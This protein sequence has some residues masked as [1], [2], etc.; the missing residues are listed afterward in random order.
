[1]EL[2]PQST[3]NY[4]TVYRCSMHL[5]VLMYMPLQICERC[6]YVDRAANMHGYSILIEVKMTRN[7]LSSAAILH[8]TLNNDIRISRIS[9]T[10]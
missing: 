3:E 2:Q 8:H 5:Y 7:L 4:L 6:G 10:M 1:M 9:A